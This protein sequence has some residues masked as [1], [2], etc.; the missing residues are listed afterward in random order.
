MF[1]RPAWQLSAACRGMDPAIFYPDRGD[2]KLLDYPLAI[3]ARCIVQVDCLD[4]AIAH[5]ETDGVWGGT[6]GKD[7]RAEFSRRFRQRQPA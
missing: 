4:H 7:R 2:S 5:H 6:S 3:C 1:E